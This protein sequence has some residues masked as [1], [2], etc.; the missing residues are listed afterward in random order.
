MPALQV[1]V[2][3]VAHGK[4]QL[5]GARQYRF[6]AKVLGFDPGIIRLLPVSS[7]DNPV[8]PLDELDS[9]LSDGGHSSDVATLVRMV[10]GQEVPFISK[11]GISTPGIGDLLETHWIHAGEIGLIIDES[12]H[13]GAITRVLIGATL[14][15]CVIIGGAAAMHTMH[16]TK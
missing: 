2:A 14:D 8:L 4:Q 15:A 13:N 3:V 12:S 5:Y 16:A 11:L 7:S 6:Q 10:E 1:Q 9:L